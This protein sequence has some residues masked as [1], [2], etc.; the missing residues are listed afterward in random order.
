MELDDRSF[1]YWDPG[2]ED[3]SDVAGRFSQIS[4]QLVEQERRRPGWQVDPGTYEIF[5]GR[6]S[7]DISGRARVEVISG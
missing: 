1:A 7:T 3:W 4:P 6:S 2:Q 5:V